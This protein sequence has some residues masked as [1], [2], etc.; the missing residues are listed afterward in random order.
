MNIISERKQIDRMSDGIQ[1]MLSL[2][3]EQ[4]VTF[5]NMLNSTSNN[6]ESINFYYITD[7]YEKS[8]SNTS[9]IGLEKERDENGNYIG[10]G[11]YGGKRYSTNEIFANLDRYL[12]KCDKESN[13]YLRAEEILNTRNLNSFIKYYSEKEKIDLD[14][15]SKVFEI[16][17]NNDTLSKF[18]DYESNK[19][20]FSVNEN[21]IPRSQYL[22][23]L[24]KIFGK[25]D[26]DGNLSSKLQI[27]SE[28]YIKNIDE[29]KQSYSKLYDQ[30]NFD[31]YV[32]PEYTFSSVD[33]TSS[34]YR[35]GDEPEW[36][37]SKSIYSD[38]IDNMPNDLSVEEK[39]IYIYCK[40]CKSFNY[41]EGYNYRDKLKKVNYESTFS[42]EHLENITVGDKITCYD[43]SRIY[44]K[45]VNDLGDD[46]TAVMILEGTNEGHALAG[47]YTDKVSAKVEAINVNSNNDLTNDIMKVK[48]GIT[49]KGIKIIS[50]RENIIPNAIH[51][52][53]SLIFNRAPKTI[54][55]YIQDL[56]KVRDEQNIPNDITLK[57]ESLLETMKEKNIYGNEFTQTLWG[58][59]KTSYFGDV[60]FQKT[61]LGELV[62]NEKGENSF[63]RH[64]LLTPDETEKESTKLQNS[65]LVDTE[66]LDF[67]TY[68]M[69]EIREKIDSNMLVY[70]DEK[71]KLPEIG[72][73]R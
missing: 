61:Y 35:E 40:M 33:F 15:L 70:E 43:F 23:H 68:T 36:N 17:T 2:P 63:K 50:D 49:P 46:I 67:S 24:G 39:A 62:E 14:L 31:K 57:I 59:L 44:S 32:L 3:D 10:R 11:Y 42:K 52:S 12:E 41:D 1:T 18:L 16:L 19:E 37:L 47:F 22:T 34:V 13:E 73:G 64:I 65:Y 45:L 28:F 54:N 21:N 9:Q 69:Q 38:I 58:I 51:K 27:S 30:I 5:L 20:Y 55:E 48:N 7:P 26:K 56:K 8:D 66:S 71:H 4:Y 53:Y 29:L 25:K 6:L 60:K 72:E